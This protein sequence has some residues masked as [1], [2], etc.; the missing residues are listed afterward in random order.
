MLGMKTHQISP[1]LLF[2]Q[3]LT[4][5]LEGEDPFYEILPELRI[6]KP[7]VFLYREKGE[8]L[9]KFPGEDP[10]PLFHG[11]AGFIVNLDPLHAAAGGSALEYEAAKILLLQLDDPFARPLGHAVRIIYFCSR[12]NETG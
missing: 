5:P 4:P 7:P 10:N 6:V 1:A 12:G 2:R 8:V 11:D 3:G 9:H